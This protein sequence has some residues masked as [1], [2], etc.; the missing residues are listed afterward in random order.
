M[1]T[2]LRGLITAAVLVVGL[3]APATGQAKNPCG[4]TGP[5]NPAV[6]QYVEQ[7]PT[8]CG[9]K[10]ATSKGG[11]AS[12]A[13]AALPPAVQQALRTQGGSDTTLLQEVATKPE[14]GAPAVTKKVSKA[15]RERIVRVQRERPKP[16]TAALGTLSGGSGGAGGRLLGLLAI[17]GASLAVALAALIARA[18][19]R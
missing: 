7:I 3:L 18:R 11:S 17:M 9:P 19:R 1:S 16:V 2:S 4:K 8:S 14:F 5:V 6:S 10:S 15:K 13:A 12:Q